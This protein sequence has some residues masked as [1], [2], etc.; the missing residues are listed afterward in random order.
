MQDLHE[1][2]GGANLIPTTPHPITKESVPLTL[3][4]EF[5]GTVEELGSGVT[6]LKVGDRVCLRP[7]IYDGTCR[8]CRDGAPN[9][10]WSNGFVGLSGTP[11]SFFHVRTTALL[12]L[13]SLGFGGGLSDYV[14]ADEDRLFKLPENVSLEVGGIVDTAP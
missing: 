1:Y 14:A 11:P 2:L 4:H 13:A 10:C 3:G 5:S 6:K 12:I 8:A 9:C 7:T